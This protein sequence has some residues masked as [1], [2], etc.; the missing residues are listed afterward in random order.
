MIVG[1]G[2]LVKC[3]LLFNALVGFSKE[4]HSTVPLDALL[5]VVID[6]LA[7]L[8]MIILQQFFILL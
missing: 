2:F 1:E 8:D 6:Q 7:D 3:L 4:N 5:E